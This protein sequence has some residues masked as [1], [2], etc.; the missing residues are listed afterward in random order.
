MALCRVELCKYHSHLSFAVSL[1]LANDTGRWSGGGAVTSASLY[2]N[3]RGLGDELVRHC[4]VFLCQR[5]KQKNC[6]TPG[7]P[8]TSTAQANPLRHF[9]FPRNLQLKEYPHFKPLS[10][11]DFGLKVKGEREWY[12]VAMQQRS[13]QRGRKTAVLVWTGQIMRFCELLELPVGVRQ[14]S[15]S[16]VSTTSRL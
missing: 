1:S 8:W 7:L 15:L 14:T 11:Y 13:R 16:P 3:C 4:T 2:R 12:A 10:F 9:A 6:S 5:G